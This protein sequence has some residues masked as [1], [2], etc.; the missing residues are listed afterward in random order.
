MR[1]R[2]RSIIVVGA[3]VTMMTWLVAGPT[4]V[5]LTAGQAEEPPEPRVFLYSLGG[6][7]LT[8]FDTA[9]LEPG[10]FPWGTAAN[11]VLHDKIT[12]PCATGYIGR[13][14]D[15]AVSADGARVYVTQSHP[16][17]NSVAVI[18]ATSSP[19]VIVD[20]IP[21]GVIPLGIALDDVRHLAYVA[22]RGN[23][24]PA[25]RT[26]SVVDTVA[27]VELE[28]IPV[29]V[30]RPH[31]IEVTP[32][33]GRAFVT[34]TEAGK[35]TIIDAIARSEIPGVSPLP[36]LSQQLLQAQPWKL[37]I[38]PSGQFVWV[39]LPGVGKMS[40]VE[41]T[42]DADD[43][44]VVREFWKVGLQPWSV[45]FSPDGWH[46]YASGG[47]TWFDM[48]FALSGPYFWEQT[49]GIG[50]V[51][52][53]V[54]PDGTRT[55]IGDYNF[56]IGVR[57]NTNLAP[58]TISNSNVVQLIAGSHTFLNRPGS[59]AIGIEAVG[60]GGEGSAPEAHAGEDLTR[61]ATA[62]S[63]PVA[64]DGSLSTGE[65][66]LEFSWSGPFPE[67]EGTVAGVSPTVTLPVG[68]HEITLTVTDGS[69][70]T[71][72]DVVSVTVTDTTEPLISGVDA[73][74]TQEGNAQGGAV[75]AFSPLASD[76]VDGDVAVTSDAPADDFF[77][78]GTPT[79]VTFT[80]SD[81]LGNTATKTTT[82]TV[83]DTTAPAFTSVPVD[84]TVPATEPG[85]GAVVPL[86]ALGP[87]AATDTVDDAVVITN[88]L[89]AV[90]GPGDT[91]VTFTA[92]DGSG[93]TVTT[94][95]TVTVVD[96]TAP[97]FTSVPP[98]MSVE[99]TGPAGAV[100]MLP[101]A[102]AQDDG[103][104][105]VVITSDAP[106]DGVF[107]LGAI[108][109][110]FTA[111]DPAGNTSTATMTV[112]VGDATP[113][114][115]TSV[116]PALTV[117]AAGA[118]GTVVTLEMLGN[119]VASDLVSE[120]VAVTNDLPPIC[121]PG[122]TV[123]T[124][125]ATDAAGNTATATTS[126]T[127]LDRTGPELTGVPPAMTVE[128]TGS[129]GALVELVAPSATDLV[130]GSV[131]VT[132]NPALPCHCGPGET[133]VTFTAT[134]AAGNSTTATTL[135][136]VLDRTAPVFTSVP[137]DVTAEATGPSGATVVL[138]AAAANDAVDANVVITNDAPAGGVFPLGSTTVTY[139]ATDASG[140]AATASTIV[141][142][143]DGTAPSFTGV[144]AGMTVEA[145]GPDGAIVELVAPSATDLVDGP[146]S[147]ASDVI[148][149]CHCGP[150]TT[151]VTFTA[152][153]AA[154][155]T[156]TA[157]TTVIV[158]D[159][160]AP[161]L[162]VPAPL[163]VNRN[164]PGGATVSLTAT[165]TDAVNGTV[166]VASD[167]PVICPVGVTLVTFVATDGAGN[168]AT[169]TTTV[170]VVN[171]APEM[172]LAAGLLNV[173]EGG[174]VTASGTVGDLD[175]GDIVTLSASAGTVVGGG[176][177]WSWSLPVADDPG[178]GAVIVSATDDQGVSAV[179]TL[180]VAVQ[181]APPEVTSVE[182]PLDP[183]ALGEPATV[184]AHFT[185]AGVLDTHTCSVNWDD[186]QPAMP[187]EVT[188]AGGT[189]SC[190][191]TYPYI[192]SGVYVATVTVT[193]DDGGSATDELDLM[194]VYDPTGGFVTGGGWI[195]SAAGSY[196]ADPSLTGT[197]NFG[198][199][200]KYKKNGT[201]PTGQTE[202]Q[203]QAGDVNFH[204]DAY[205]WLVV[206]GPIAQ[207]QGYGTVNG[208][209]DYGFQITVHDAKLT[210]E[211]GDV[212]RFRI[213][214]WDRG[215]GAIF[216]DN[217][218]GAPSFIYD[219]NPQELDQGSIVIHTKGN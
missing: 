100:V 170:T 104:G 175:P 206:V 33:G 1:S 179:V 87:V 81:S 51:D 19:M 144:P 138:A 82:V 41:N 17:C 107:P 172:G 204:I 36:L 209:G 177:T 39:A 173:T 203:F 97:V 46:A 218:P 71:G 70:V 14:S 146:V 18:D 184:T 185:D 24:D 205:D 114:T 161:S 105:T 88:D 48:Y 193:D 109:V 111:T 59:I 30:G 73:T 166:A 142:V 219:A 42:P 15:L 202:F 190:T 163:T 217:V 162:S 130:D 213:A 164:V 128:A 3:L 35:L 194:V 116:P 64:L 127:V 74:L 92:T 139:T 34:L 78:L 79:V 26:V 155:N 149:P 133:L 174:T 148:L 178:P 45:A 76:L 29:S 134:D 152:S 99:A 115:F 66:P 40:I 50:G 96:G 210:P 160:T 22:N 199:V 159:T 137:G 198:F 167:L 131:V 38:S 47:Y 212:D 101:A 102:T 119:A 28:Q 182:Q 7:L 21:V 61:E 186:G 6:G 192:A 103:G 58:E 126:V 62:P 23:E 169:A 183:I 2:S 207:F 129:E 80:A 154:G 113:P 181:N 125:T 68:T 122:V 65:A 89:P 43:I 25:T 215:T 176:G 9:N 94:T 201:V 11:G 95:A 63:T 91:I 31:S 135:V 60:A 5:M 67:G 140:N 165:A 124:F 145:T 195:T 158:H 83:V 10:V 141:T 156:A 187:G 196:A 151:L 200:A 143:A 197:A 117:E 12:V 16:S 120:P 211:A 108:V 53:A 208:S 157:T 84:I 189:G 8:R 72:T 90:C 191:A 188:E 56:G 118:D 112:T 123:V 93:N 27:N 121:A 98:A 136:T 147:V 20:T 180:P 44:R 77:P 110:T 37:A 214:I 54:H 69:A 168:T 153:D 13:P 75:H 55:Y 52:V 86:E 216:Y 106:V 132:S 85:G 171:R 57:A 49:L 32:D 150:G 4:S